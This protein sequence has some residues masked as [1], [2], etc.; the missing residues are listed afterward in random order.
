MLQIDERLYSMTQGK[1]GEPFMRA[2]AE[3]SNETSIIWGELLPLEQIL[4]NDEQVLAL[5]KSYCVEDV[6]AFSSAEQGVK[7]VLQDLLQHNYDAHVLQYM[8]LHQTIE[9]QGLLRFLTGVEMSLPVQEIK[10]LV[11]HKVE[12]KWLIHPIWREDEPFWR[13]LYAK[14]LYSILMQ[15]NIVNIPNPAL[16]ILEL[17]KALANTMSKNRVATIIHQLINHITQQSELS[18]ELK[19]LHLNDVIIHFTSG[20]RHFRKLR[21][22]IAQLE[23]MWSEEGQWALTEKERTLL[24]YILLEEAVSRKDTEQ[25]LIQGLFLIEDDRLNNHIVELMVEYNEVLK[26]I[27]PQ[28]ETIVKAYDKNCGEFILYHVIGALAK[29]NQFER[30]VALLKDYEI[31]SCLEIYQYINGAQ[32]VDLLHKLE[33]SV[34]RGIASIVDGSPQN[35]RQSL[36]KW[37]GD[38]RVKKGPYAEIALMTSKHVCNI[39]KSLWATEQFE[40]FERLIEIYRKYLFIPAHFKQLRAFVATTVRSNDF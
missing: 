5:V 32:D 33:A 25:I 23:A 8:M 29:A 39:L 28:P 19:M 16:I 31:A 36:A 7:K 38:Y 2:I 40:L 27:P 22:R 18:Y 26:I 24:A 21:K 6:A 11:V 4:V 13:T 14:K 3:I 34:Q 9:T 1:I 15:V 30:I 10:A 17:Q 35:I 20:S 37:Q 12:N